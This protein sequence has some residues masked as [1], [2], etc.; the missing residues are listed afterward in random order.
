M[1]FVLSGVAKTLSGNYKTTRQ[2][3]LKETFIPD[4]YQK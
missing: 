3:P 2:I 1:I 4:I